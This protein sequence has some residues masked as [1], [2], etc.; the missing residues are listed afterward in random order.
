MQNNSISIS[1]LFWY[2]KT[3]H[4]LTVRQ[5]KKKYMLQ[6]FYLV[7]NKALDPIFYDFIQQ[8]ELYSSQLLFSVYPMKDP[9]AICGR[10]DTS[11]SLVWNLVG[12]YTDSMIVKCQHLRSVSIQCANFQSNQCLCVQKKKQ[13]TRIPCLEFLFTIRNS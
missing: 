7:N 2:K 5:N 3:I 4:L 12:I 6:I 11:K 10:G 13:H 8:R 1:S 9:H